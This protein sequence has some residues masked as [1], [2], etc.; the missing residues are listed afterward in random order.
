MRIHIRFLR[1][2]KQGIAR[3][4]NN[5]LNARVASA[6]H[7]F[8]SI[9]GLPALLSYPGTAIVLRKG[10]DVFVTHNAET[11]EN[12]QTVLAVAY[13]KDMECY[14]QFKEVQKDYSL[15][16]TALGQISLGHLADQLTSELAKQIAAAANGPR[17]LKLKARTEIAGKVVI[18]RV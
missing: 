18:K 14:E 9:R 3:S 17:S 15:R 16:S 12:R 11:I 8:L 1:R 13:F 6:I 7:T 2:R 10:Y 4:Q 5:S